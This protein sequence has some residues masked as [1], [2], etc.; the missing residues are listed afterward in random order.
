MLDLRVR[1]ASIDPKTGES[2][3]HGQPSSARPERETRSLPLVGKCARG[4]AGIKFT[5]SAKSPWVFAQPSGFPALTR[6]SRR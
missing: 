1:E 5:S 3:R 6:T 2:A 4:A